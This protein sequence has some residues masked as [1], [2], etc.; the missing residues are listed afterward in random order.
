[1]ATLAGFVSMLIAF[2]IGDGVD[3]WLYL[4][5]VITGIVSIFGF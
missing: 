4:L 5:A 2:G 1:L 3:A